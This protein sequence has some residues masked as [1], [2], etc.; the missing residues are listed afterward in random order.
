MR[1]SRECFAHLLEITEESFDETLSEAH[2]RGREA[3]SREK[4][5]FIA[6]WYLANTTTYREIALSFGVSASTAF[7]AIT[8]VIRLLNSIKNNV[9]RWPTDQEMIEGEQ[10]FFDDSK[11]E[12]VL[13]CIDGT[14]IRIKSPGQLVQHDYVDRYQQHSYNLAAVCDH[15]LSFTFISAA[16]PGGYHDQRVLRQSELWDHINTVDAT[17]VF[18][19]GYYHILGDSAYKLMERILV[20]FKDHGQL[21]VQQKR[22]N[23]QLSRARIVIENAFGWLKGRFRR[24]KYI[25]AEQEK[26]PLI[27]TACCVLHNI[28]LRFT[29]FK[30]YYKLLNE[31]P[32]QHPQEPE[33]YAAGNNEDRTP[34]AKGMSKRNRIAATLSNS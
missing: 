32:P 23:L 22:F 5:F 28:S 9:I 31:A 27:I 13:G 30:E 15:N 16:S 25:D 12:G 18:P 7:D 33:D 26:I 11:I 21:T 1:I 24:L 6:I 20:P 3:L 4:M 19:S 2:A 29:E 34:T 8:L 10:S 14:L 17:H